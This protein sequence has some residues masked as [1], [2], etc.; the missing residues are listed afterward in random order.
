[1]WDCSIKFLFLPKADEIEKIWIIIQKD[2][3]I[4]DYWL[5]ISYARSSF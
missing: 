4:F 3:K 5:Y 2:V 1:M